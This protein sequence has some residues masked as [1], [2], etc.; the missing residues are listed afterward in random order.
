MSLPGVGNSQNNQVKQEPLG[1][2]KSAQNG[3]SDITQS[4]MTGGNIAESVEG[5]V[6]GM[7]EDVVNQAKATVQEV[8]KDAIAQGLKR[9]FF[10][11]DKADAASSKAKT[12]TDITKSAA[13]IT[14]TQQKLLSAGLEALTQLV[15]TGEVDINAAASRIIDAVKLIE[16]KNGAA[17]SLQEQKQQ[18]MEENEEIAKQLAEFGIKIQASKSEGSSGA[19]QTITIVQEAKDGEPAK[20]IEMNVGGSKGDSGSKETQGFPAEVQE[21]LA[22]Y[23]ENIALIATVDASLSQISGDA[24]N[25]VVQVQEDQSTIQIS[26]E[27]LTQ[28]IQIK[29]NEVAN[30]SAAAINQQVQKGNVTLKSDVVIST[31]NGGVDIGTAAAA[32]GIAAGLTAGTLGFGSGE[33]AKVVANG[34]ADGFSASVRAMTGSSAAGGIVSNVMAGK[35]VGDALTQT[36]V[37]QANNFIAG[38]VNELASGLQVGE[39]DVGALVA[40]EITAGLEI[41]APV[42]GD[43]PKTA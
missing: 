23:Q 22:K 24:S 41:K 15:T 30:E 11:N 21:L 20:T 19:E 13:Q 8:I 10:G 5:A 33:A 1:V 36:V 26:K 18:A 16:D 34:V 39:L 4:I 2:K 35:S 9:L 38:Q 31:V 32:P 37:N 27:Q 7:A 25:I 17:E 3:V 6:T 43:K 29:A 14:A 28:D 12:G 42:D 40:P